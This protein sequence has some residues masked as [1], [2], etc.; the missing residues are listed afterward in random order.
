MIFLFKVG[1]CNTLKLIVIGLNE[2][3]IMVFPQKS[4]ISFSRL[5]ANIKLS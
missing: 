2:G 3:A 1:L 4:L 5:A